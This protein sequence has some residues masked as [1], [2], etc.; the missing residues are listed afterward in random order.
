MG[1]DKMLMQDLAY[2][3][4]REFLLVSYAGAY[5]AATVSGCNTRKYHGL[6]VAPQPQLDGDDHVLLS[7]LHETI[8]YNNHAYSLAVHRYPGEYNPDGHALITMFSADPLPYWTFKT[9]DAVITKELL[10]DESENRISARYTLKEGPS[11]VSLK[12]QP[13]VAFRNMHTVGKA[14]PFANLSVNIIDNG[15]QMRL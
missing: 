8:S 3:T 1:I 6:L 9:G 12:L 2:V 15:V 13:F 4:S 14:N 7:A 10:M 5:A 11:S